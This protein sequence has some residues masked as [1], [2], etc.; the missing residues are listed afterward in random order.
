MARKT[1]ITLIRWFTLKQHLQAMDAA[2]PAGT[3]VSM[4][5]FFLL[6]VRRCPLYVNLG[7][8]SRIDVI[9]IYSDIISHICIYIDGICQYIDTQ[10]LEMNIDKDVAK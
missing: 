3:S 10:T 7:T 1:A 8:H 9:K 5:A 4:P 2:G 6:R